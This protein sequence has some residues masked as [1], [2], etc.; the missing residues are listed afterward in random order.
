[1]A[2]VP[3]DLKYTAEHEWAKVAGATIRVG[4]TDYAQEALGD[5]VFV[6]LP[7]VGAK[8][9]QGDAFG[10]V[11]STKSVSDLYAPVTGTVT[12]RNE[13]LDARPELINN[14]PYGEGWI[15]EIEVADAGQLDGLLDAATYGTLSS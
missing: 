2:D 8:V 1:M 6:S 4:V 5:V 12:A 9:G 14:D 10:E 13:E 15:V 11:E 3:D 7:E